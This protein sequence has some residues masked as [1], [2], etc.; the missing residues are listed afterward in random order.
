MKHIMLVSAALLLFAGCVGPMPSAT[1]TTANPVWQTY[2]KI[3]YD[4]ENRGEQRKISGYVINEY[5]AAMSSVQVLA[6]ALDASEQVLAQKIVYLPGVL[7][8]FGRSY[9]EVGGLP[10]APN[11]RVTVWSFDRIESDGKFPR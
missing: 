9:F 6:Q 4:V 1:V 8:G 3:A 11:Y 7:P 10:P 2:F 5:G